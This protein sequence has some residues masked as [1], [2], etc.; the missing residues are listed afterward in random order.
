MPDTLVYFVS[1][2]GNYYEHV[3][4]SDMRTADYSDWYTE[5]SKGYTPSYNNFGMSLVNN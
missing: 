4:L 3:L 1:A 5:T 2:D